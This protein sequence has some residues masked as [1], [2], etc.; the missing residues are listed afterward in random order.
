MTGGA[1]GAGGVGDAGG[2]STGGAGGNGGAGIYG[3]G[4][5]TTLNN[6]SGTLTGGAG[7][8]GGIGDTGGDGGA[9][10]FGFLNNDAM[11]AL[12]NHGAITG[13]AGGIGGD[14]T[15][16]IGS[17]GN[18]GSGNIAVFNYGTM[19]ALNNHGAITGGAGGA[20]G[21]GVGS[22][23]FGGA[24]GFGVLNQNTI[25]NLN[26]NSGTTITGGAG[27]AGG[28]GSSGGA[29]GAGIYNAGMITNLSNQGAI[30]GGAGGAVSAI[31]GGGPGNG[32]TGIYNGG[33]ITNLI[34]QGSL[35]GGAGGAGG[36]GL[37]GIAILNQGTIV[38]LENLQGSVGFGASPVSIS[39]NLPNTYNIIV[40]DATHFGM[41]H[42]TAVNVGSTMDFGISA[43]SGGSA[44]IG[45]TY[46]DIITGVAPGE[47][48]GTA[49]FS[50]GSSVDGSSNGYTYRL[51]YN[52]LNT[53]WL[54]ILSF[55]SSGPSSADTQTSMQRSAYA[56]RGAYNNQSSLI[57]TALNYDCG[58]FDK[59]NTCS[60]I[61]GRFTSVDDPSMNTSGALFIASYR[62]ADNLRIGGY[63]DQNLSTNNTSGIHLSNGSPMGGVFANWNQ[64][65]D[66]TGFELRLAAGYNDKDIAISR[67]VIG[68]SE[69]GYGK[70]SLVSTAALATLSYGSYL[71]D[72]GWI[73]SPYLGIRYTNIKRNA[74]SEH[75]TTDVTAPLTYAELEQ[76]TTTA[77]LGARLNGQLK[78]NVYLMGS[79]GI[80]QDLDHSVD[81]YSATGVSGIN[82]FKFNKN[83][84]RTRPV[85]SVGAVYAV[86]PA[87][88][89]SLQLQYRQ[90]AF[91]AS[92]STTAIA[93]YQIGF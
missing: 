47:I 70:A 2:G 27:G 90:E 71:G 81:A 19:N 32:G 6:N 7:G 79:V 67:E 58:V 60:S 41:L 84:K 35:S 43:L 18:G 80:E 87:Q 73:A 4:A 26:N 51:T 28:A 65:P 8:A 39:G 5:M 22:G 59:N 56:L 13:G 30:A 16:G 11:N 20:G 17:A 49:G 23:G 37:A 15:F 85:V 68:T 88:A 25:T 54:N 24:G 14:I 55:I 3:S 77:L 89:I 75:S 31:P 40:K 82:A 53:W 48:N 57:N 86:A 62:F 76:K 74:Y 63:L 72:T 66:R 34:N 83:I 93:A 33:T 64:N 78:E 69:A 36:G 91:Q 45:H 10:G 1:G 21:L 52:S 12:N 9:G 46:G 29:G 92:G 44:T 42:A 61:G 50:V 38:T